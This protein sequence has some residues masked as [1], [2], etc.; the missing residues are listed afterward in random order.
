MAVGTHV[1]TGGNGRV[2]QYEVDLVHREIGN[3]A[4]ECSFATDDTNRL[5][6]GERWF[7]KA[8][9]DLLRNDVVNSHD[10]AQRAP[11]RTRARRMRAPG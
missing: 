7:E 11:R 1:K 10:K 8:V 5:L 3:Q 2:G 6:Q 9:R 4:F